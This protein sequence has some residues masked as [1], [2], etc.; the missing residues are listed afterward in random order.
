MKLLDNVRIAV[1]IWTPVVLAVTAVAI[2]GVIALVELRG[3]MLDDRKAKIR[4]MVDS[5]QAIVIHNHNQAQAGAWTHLAMSL[6][7]FPFASEP[8]S[9]P[10]ALGALCHQVA[11]SAA[12]GGVASRAFPS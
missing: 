8:R 1:K 7:P 3:T 9:I 12:D 2:V 10:C 11:A 4:A 6:P 5:A